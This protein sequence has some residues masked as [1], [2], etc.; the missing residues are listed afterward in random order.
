M[1]SMQLQQLDGGAQLLDLHL[2]HHNQK[3]HAHTSAA[4]G[5]I[6]CLQPLL[7]TRRTPGPTSLVVGN[8]VVKC[9][10]LWLLS[11]HSVGPARTSKTTTLQPTPSCNS[12]QIPRGPAGSWLLS[13]TRHPA[14]SSKP[15]HRR[16]PSSLY[17]TLLPLLPPHSPAPSVP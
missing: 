17:A 1:W 14:H 11:R 2:K 10:W 5:V 15:V 3:M 4:G 7:S 9:Q 12:M 13:R 16:P 6:P 8:T